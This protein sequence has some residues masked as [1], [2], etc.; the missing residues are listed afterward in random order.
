MQFVQPNQLLIYKHMQEVETQEKTKIYIA[1]PFFRPGERDRIE[2]VRK[3]FNEDP[4][5]D[6]YDTFYPM[7]H[8]IKDGDKMTNW[9]W[10]KAVFEMDIKALEQ[11]DIVV[12]IYDK[13]YSDS[14]TAWELGYAYALGIPVILLCTDLSADNSIMPLCAATKIYDFNKFVAGEHW[15]FD[16]FNVNSLK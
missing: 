10:A 16:L 11:S 7:D 2:Q 9:D 6:D 13:H 3:L 4:F 15:D 5:F 1:G 14:G 12:A 8:T